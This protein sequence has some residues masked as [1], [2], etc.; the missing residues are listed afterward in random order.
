MPES[1]PG[2]S[3]NDLTEMSQAQKDHVHA[4]IQNKWTGPKECPICGVEQWERSDHIFMS[5]AVNGGNVFLT[6]GPIYPFVMLICK[7]C[8]YTHLFNALVMTVPNLGITPM[9]D[10]NAK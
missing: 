2:A 8:G 6:A 4:W 9:E 7:N 3:P 1:L 10:G 5:P